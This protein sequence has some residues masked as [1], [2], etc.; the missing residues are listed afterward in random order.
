VPSF[1]SSVP[2]IGAI[3]ES[4][5]ICA[6]DEFFRIVKGEEDNE[7]LSTLN[8]L[9]LH[10]RY[11]NRT[12]KSDIDAKMTSKLLTVTNPL[13]GCGFEETILRLPP[14]TIDRILIWRQYQSHYNWVRR[15]NNVL[16]Q[17]PKIDKYKFL[18]IYD[19]CNSFKA[20]FSKDKVFK[21][22][23]ELKAK[24]PS[25]MEDI[26]ESRYTGHH[27]MCLIDGLVKARCLFEGDVSFEANDKD[28]ETFKSMWEDLVIGWWENI[29]DDD[30]ER[31]LTQEQKAM[32]KIIEDNPNIWDYQLEKK[33]EEGNIT[34]QHNYK[35]LL[36]LKIIKVDNRKVSVVED[37]DV[38]S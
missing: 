27:S 11:S 16:Y 20:K 8:N 35:R 36:N 1:S 12:G 2:K 30:A 22:T 6:V 14:S 19:Y 17:E 29:S 31:L 7:K 5:R 10:T 25:F 9:L 26:Y 15:G 4:R 28:Y 21:I 38:I 18:S 34:Y 23:D 33:C 13:Y 3:L 24:C 32:I 37:R